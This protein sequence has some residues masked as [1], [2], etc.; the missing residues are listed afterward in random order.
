MRF[1]LLIKALADAKQA[2]KFQKVYFK[3]TQIC[4]VHNY[5]LPRGSLQTAD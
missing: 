4:F 5:H 2:I 3:C 1:K